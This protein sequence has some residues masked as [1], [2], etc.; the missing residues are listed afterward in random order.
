MKPTLAKSTDPKINFFDKTAIKSKSAKQ[1]LSIEK[2]IRKSDKI[3]P[4]S[5]KNLN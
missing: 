4:K 1:S 5:S 2:N 3:K